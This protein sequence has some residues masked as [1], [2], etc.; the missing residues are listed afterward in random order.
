MAN[1]TKPKRIAFDEEMIVAYTDTCRDIEQAFN[2]VLL[3]RLTYGWSRQV[4]E[5]RMRVQWVQAAPGMSDELVVSNTWPNS[6]A[7]TLPAFL[8]QSA[9]KVH[10]AVE[11]ESH[12]REGARL[13]NAP[14]G[15]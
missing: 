2:T 15:A 11:A 8:Y 10:R 9:F 3:V 7:Q 4:I 14:A 13:V 5:L 6:H 12:R 1:R